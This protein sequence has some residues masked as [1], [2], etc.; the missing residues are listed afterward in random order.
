MDLS[1]IT[2]VEEDHQEAI[3]APAFSPAAQELQGAQGET[4]E[5]AIEAT[6]VELLTPPVP[7]V[8][9]QVIATSKS[10]LVRFAEVHVVKGETLIL[11]WNVARAFFIWL[12]GL[13]YSDTFTF[14]VVNMPAGVR[15]SMRLVLVDV[16]GYLIHGVWARDPSWRGWPDAQPQMLNGYE[17]TSWDGGAHIYLRE[18]GLIEEPWAK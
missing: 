3:Q 5:L 7:Q 2:L 17:L 9:E 12:S 10:N 14:D 15:T 6:I 1:L 4:L 11:D 8:N 16:N 13:W 18:T